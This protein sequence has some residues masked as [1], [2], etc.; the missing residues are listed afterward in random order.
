M[1]LGAVFK[2]IDEEIDQPLD[3]R[4]QELETCKGQYCIN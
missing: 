3:Q 1:M 2:Y 4:N